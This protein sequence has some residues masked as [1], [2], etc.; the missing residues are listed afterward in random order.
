[1]A[2]PLKIFMRGKRIGMLQEMLHRMGF[3]MDDQK[4]LFGVHTRDAVKAI[5]KQHNCQATGI[6]DDA[7]FRLIQTGQGS[8]TEPAAPSRT[9][10]IDHLRLEA[11]IRLLERKGVLLDGELEAELNRPQPTSLI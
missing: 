11:L 3:P 7:F 6:A 2:R 4:G 9:Q 5:Q 10:S 8:A 1:M